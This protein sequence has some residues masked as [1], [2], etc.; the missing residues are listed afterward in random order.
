MLY[1]KIQNI[2]RPS[3]TFPPP[4]GKES[5]ATDGIIISTSLKSVSKPF[6]IDLT[7]LVQ[8]PQPHPHMT[9]TSEINY[10]LSNK[11]NSQEQPGSKKKCKG[12]KNK[13]SSL[14]YK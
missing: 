5:H 1:H 14:Q 8:D 9:S 3:N 12:N 13:G 2:L 11:G 6:D 7:A 10:V 4:L